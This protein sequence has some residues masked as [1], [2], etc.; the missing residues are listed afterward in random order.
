MVVGVKGGCS[1]SGGSWG[2]GLSRSCAS[3]S[4]CGRFRAGLVGLGGAGW[5]RGGRVGLGVSWVPVA[6]GHGVDGLL[7]CSVGVLEACGQRWGVCV[8]RE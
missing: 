5:C 4:M 2:G 8:G 7:R 6:E 3:T 1:G